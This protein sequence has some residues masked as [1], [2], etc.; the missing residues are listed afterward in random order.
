MSI[1]NG[2]PLHFSPHGVCDAVDAT[3]V[4]DG[5]MAAL[6]NLIPDPSTANLFQC[7]PASTLETNFNGFQNPGFISV[8]EVFGNV[9]YGLIATARN[10]GHDEPFAFNLVTKTFSPISGVTAANTPASPI[11]TGDW[12]PPSMALVGVNLLFTSQGFNFGGGFAFGV[13]NISNP[14]ALVWTAQNT[15]ANTLPALPQWVASFNGRAWFL[16]TPAT[17]QPGAYFTDILTL[18][19]TN[20]NQVITFDDNQVLTCA[21]GLGLFNQAGG[22]VQALMVF[23]NTANVYQITGDAALSTLARN[24]LNVAT[25]TLAANSVTNTPKGLAFLAPDGLRLIDFYARISDPIGVDGQGINVPFIYVVTPS[26]VQASSNQNVL[27]VSVQNGKAVGAPQQDWWFDISRQKWT[28][29]HT[30]PASMISAFN[31]TF[32]LAPLVLPGVL[33][34]SDV[35]QSATSTFAENGIA[36]QFVWRTCP[37]PDPK[38]MAYFAMVETTLNLALVSGQSPVTVLA[39]DQ[40]QSVLGSVSISVGITGTIWGQFSWG[41]ALWG[42]SSSGLFP[43]ALEWTQPLVFRRL[44]LQATGFCAGGVQIGDAFLRY[45]QLGYMTV[46]PASSVVPF[47]TILTTEAGVPLTTEGGTEL[48]GG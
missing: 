35:A 40:N 27:R 3:N 21:A 18:N 39:L 6:T 45:Q 7:R 36:M 42:G 20:A 37:L 12:T 14:S 41:N 16:V 8:M 32:I 47:G 48:T 15:T 10:P 29:P 30:F 28:G 34:Q 2:V 46:D 17:G 33:F 1:R 26:R 5:A 38:A 31:N 24:S 43:R 9:A 13:L 44:S 22:I 11:T 19:I 23:K 4:Q 25:G